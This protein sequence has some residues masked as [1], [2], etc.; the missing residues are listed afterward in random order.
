MEPG[1][2]W[3]NDENINGFC[4]G[5]NAHLQETELC[6][7][8]DTE[9]QVSNPRHIIIWRSHLPNQ[10]SGENETE[11]LL[12]FVRDIVKNGRIDFFHPNAYH[13]IICNENNDHWTKMIIDMRYQMLFIE[14]TFM[15]YSDGVPSLNNLQIRRI[16]GLVR[17][18]EFLCV[19]T[20][21]MTLQSKTG[22]SAKE[23]AEQ[24]TGITQIGCQNDG[25]DCGVLVAM[26]SCNNAI[27]DAN[28]RINQK[29]L[30]HYIDPR[31]FMLH[32]LSRGGLVSNGK[33]VV[34]E[35]SDILGSARYG[36]RLCSWCNKNDCHVKV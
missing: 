10:F 5:I 30:D 11:D 26:N 25:T 14:D 23:W 3:L 35:D 36:S 20:K 28:I 29:E 18:M 13:E 17:C 22:F 32:C 7:L 8:K 31:K 33:Y 15:S 2:I 27:D 24:R 19:T 1:R 34:L 9:R 4:E 16:L 21:G 6:S 12:K